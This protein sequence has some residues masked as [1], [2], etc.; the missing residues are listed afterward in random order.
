M[1]M[2]ALVTVMT[3]LIGGCAQTNNAALRGK[4]ISVCKE[5][6][7]VGTD[8]DFWA[9]MHAAEALTAADQTQW[10]KNKL[11]QMLKHGWNAQHMCGLCR[12]MVRAGADEY[13]QPMVSVLMRPEYGGATHAAESLF[14]VGKLGQRDLMEKAAAGK[15]PVLGMMACAALVR[16]GDRD[17]LQRR[18][19]GLTSA[20]ERE[21]GVACWVLG[22]IGEDS[23]IPG[24]RQASADWTGEAKVSARV[25]LAR[26]GD[27]QCRERIFDLLKDGEE[28]H[29]TAVCEAL[30]AMKLKAARPHLIPLL[31]DARLDVRVRAAHALIGV[32]EE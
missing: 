26:L 1:R 4:C 11:R 20:V 24:I 8:D 7:D 30:A 15:D 14:K 16:A 29:L 13:E 18:R 5:A 27:P 23:D 25:A 10:V 19:E 12:E 9:R 22:Q 32:L 6:F 21:R 2:V 28:K 31:D 3:T 17:K